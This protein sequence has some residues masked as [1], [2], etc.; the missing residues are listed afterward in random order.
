M[1]SLGKQNRKG[2]IPDEEIT[3]VA[4]GNGKDIPSKDKVAFLKLL[5]EELDKINSPGSIKNR[6]RGIR[7]EVAGKNIKTGTY[8]AK[9]GAER[10]I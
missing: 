4:P 6:G 2:K 9:K 10:E 8:R 1:I 5:S 7:L 3:L